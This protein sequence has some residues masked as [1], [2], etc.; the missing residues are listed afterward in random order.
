VQLN[1]DILELAWTTET[2]IVVEAIPAKINQKI[3]KDV[4]FKTMTV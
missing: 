4:P 3:V 1:L 2:S